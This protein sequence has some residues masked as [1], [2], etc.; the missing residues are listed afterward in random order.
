M[1][2]GALRSPPKYSPFFG[3]SASAEPITDVT[4]IWSP[5]TAGELHPAPGIWVVQATFSVVLHLSGRLGSSATP[6][7]PGPLNPGQLSLAAAP[8]SSMATKNAA[9]IYLLTMMSSTGLRK[10][11]ET[12]AI[13]RLPWSLCL[14]SSSLSDTVQVLSGSHK[15]LTV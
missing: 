10:P 8:P 13:S 5:Q 15:N 4:N 6:S 9:R 14:F 12:S 7:E 2:V 1:S 11:F 3:F